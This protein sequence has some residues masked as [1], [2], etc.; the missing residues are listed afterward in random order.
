MSSS[1]RAMQ[2]KTENMPDNSVIFCVRFVMYCAAPFLNANL[3]AIPSVTDR[4]SGISSSVAR[5]RGI[6]GS[7]VK[8]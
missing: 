6:T 2:L 8:N 3:R 1:A 7:Q 5:C 4:P